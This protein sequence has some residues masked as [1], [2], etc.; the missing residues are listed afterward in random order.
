MLSADNPIPRL[1]R[2]SVPEMWDSPVSISLLSGRMG[3]PRLVGARPGR[4]H[5]LGR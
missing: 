3:A 1:F 2:T 4:L 5:Q